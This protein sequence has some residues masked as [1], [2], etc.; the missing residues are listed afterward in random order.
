MKT[1]LKIA[2]IVLIGLIM[3]YDAQA[4]KKAEDPTVN[5]IN[6]GSPMFEMIIGGESRDSTAIR[7]LI[8]DRVRQYVAMEK[9]RLRAK[10]REVDPTNYWVR[11]IHAPEINPLAF[12]QAETLEENTMPID[13]LKVIVVRFKEI[14]AAELVWYQ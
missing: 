14:E 11:L 9:A 7:I 12:R 2:L 8:T 1:I 4:Q 6:T 13:G 3:S 5:Q 10:S